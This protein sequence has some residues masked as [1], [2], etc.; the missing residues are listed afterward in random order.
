MSSSTTKTIGVTA[1]IKDDLLP[2]R[3]AIVVCIAI[4]PSRA[5]CTSTLLLTSRPRKR[6]GQR[7]A[8]ILLAERLGQAGHDPLIEKAGRKALARESR[9]EDDW[10]RVSLPKQFPMQLGS[11][12]AGHYDVQDQAL[13]FADAIASQELFRR[14]EG[15][16]RVAQHHEKVRQRLA[17]RLIIIDDCDEWRGNRHASLRLAKSMRSRRKSQEGKR[18]SSC[19]CIGAPCLPHEQNAPVPKGMPDTLVWVCDMNAMSGNSPRAANWCLRGNLRF[20]TLMACAIG[21]ERMKRFAVSRKPSWRTQVGRLS[22]A[23]A[24]RDAPGR[25]SRSLHEPD[26]RVVEGAKCMPNCPARREFPR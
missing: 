25:P 14:R 18:V 15:S 24:R 20:D 10:N 12:H 5:C 13:R 19:F 21:R 17:H 4:Y 26:H 9:N 23:G 3:T 7:R 11:R 6:G 2:R 22:Q 1:G 8:E 16:R